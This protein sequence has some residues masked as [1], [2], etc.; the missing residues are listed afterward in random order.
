MDLENDSPEELKKR[1]L[2]T[3]SIIQELREE[4]DKWQDEC[5]NG[6]G[7]NESIIIERSN[8]VSTQETRIYRRDM[9]VLEEDLQQKKEKIRELTEKCTKLELEN[10]RLGETLKNVEENREDDGK[11]FESLKTRFHSLEE[12]LLAETN[13]VC[14]FK[15]L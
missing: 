9:T 10:K 5:V 1:L 4:R 14:V 8:R 12:Q 2:E 13:E 15:K 3:E 7:L 11:Q 6:A